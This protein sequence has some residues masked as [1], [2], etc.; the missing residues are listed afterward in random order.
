MYS[1]NGSQITRVDIKGKYTSKVYQC[2]LYEICSNKTLEHS[3][4]EYDSIF[5]T[6]CSR[7]AVSRIK[8]KALEGISIVKKNYCENN[9]G[10][11]G[12]MCPMDKTRYSEFPSDCYHMDHRDGN[13]ENNVIENIVTICSLCHAR[14]GKESGDFNG[15][16]KSSRKLRKLE[17]PSSDSSSGRMLEGTALTS[18]SAMQEDQVQPSS[19]LLNQ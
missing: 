8:G 10:L 5:K 15:S 6:E 9:D 12:F 2:W 19:E 17:P 11:L 3:R 13:H 4:W 1:K 16:K 7:C 18:S 14:K